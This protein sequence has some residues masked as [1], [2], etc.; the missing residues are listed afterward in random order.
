M[1]NILKQIKEALES[2]LLEHDI[3]IDDIT[4]GKENNYNF[5]RI[6]LDKKNGLDLDTIVMA[7]NIINPIID[8]LDL[9]SDSYVLD[10]ISKGS[11]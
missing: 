5:L 11:E 2:P 7:T 4:Y 8:E 9:I 3:I 1:E 6:T 10:V